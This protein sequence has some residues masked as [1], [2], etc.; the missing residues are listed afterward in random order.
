MPNA[1]AP[2]VPTDNSPDVILH[3]FP[4]NTKTESQQ[5]PPAQ[6]KYR[7]EDQLL[8]TTPFYASAAYSI[9][10][11]LAFTTAASHP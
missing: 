5:R 8:I 2:A 6:V 10:A 3:P 11:W 1:G 4:R 7:C 9:G